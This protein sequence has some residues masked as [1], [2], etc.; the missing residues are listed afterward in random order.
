MKTYI[1]GCPIAAPRLQAL[2]HFGLHGRLGSQQPRRF[3]TTLFQLRDPQRHG[4]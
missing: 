1:D 2:A 4:Q 3:D